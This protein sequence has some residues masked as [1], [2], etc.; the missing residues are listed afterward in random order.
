MGTRSPCDSVGMDLFH[1]L[2]KVTIGDGRKA[3]FW[4]SAWL[5]GMRLKHIAPLI[6][7]IFRSK[8]WCMRKAC[9]MTLGLIR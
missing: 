7:D 4:E 9:Q 3:S 2:M 1:M 6:Y 8:K 5:D